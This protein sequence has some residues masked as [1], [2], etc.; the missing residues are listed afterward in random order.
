MI[1][2]TVK[3]LAELRGC[4]VRTIQKQIENGKWKHEVTVNEKDVKK[5]L[6]PLTEL[7]EE[8]QVKYYTQTNNKTD[9]L[10]RR[11]AD[12]I[13]DTVSSNLYI[14]EK[15]VDNKVKKGFEEY[16]ALERERI[17]MWRDIVNE[18]QAFRNN[19]CN[20]GQADKDFVYCKRVE[21]MQKGIELKISKDILYKKHKF[22]KN[23]D[24]DGLLENRGK[25]KRENTVLTEQMKTV[26][27]YYYFN[28]NKMQLSKCVGHV[29]EWYDMHYPDEVDSIP[30]Y[31]T[32]NRYAK[33][34][35]KAVVRYLREGEKVAFDSATPYIMR[36]Y[37]EIEANDVWVADCHTIDVT[38]QDEDGKKH[39]LYIVAFLDA[40][41]GVLAGWFVTDRIC[42]DST[43][44][45]LRNA[46]ERFGIPKVVYFDNGREFLTY[47]L[48]GKGHRGKK[49]N[50][51]ETPPT[52]IQRLGIEMTNAI[53]RN[54]KAKPIE[55]TFYTFK[56][57]VSKLFDTYTGGHVLER[58]EDYNKRVK[59]GD[60][61]FDKDL[62]EYINL[63]VDGIYNVEPYGGCESQYKGMSRVD[64]WNKSIQKTI[65][66]TA[67]EQDLNLMLLRSSKYQKVKR[68]GVFI[69]IN[70]VKLNYCNDTTWT[71]LD[72][73]VYVRYNP[74]DPSSVRL[75]NKEDKYLD[76]V[77]LA[78]DLMVGYMDTAEE[79]AKG[80]EFSGNV[81]R[82]IKNMA[83]S[84]TANMD[85]SEKI[86]VID[87]AIRKAKRQIGDSKPIIP[88]TIQIVQANEEM[89]LPKAV[90]E[91][92]M[93]DLATMIENNTKRSRGVNID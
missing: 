7:S 11:E 78:N 34:I 4:T 40:K 59:N 50:I 49:N 93:I 30:S 75:Y 6:I 73:E 58:P 22:I 61:V 23:N 76:T 26:F 33:T 18:W 88:K 83:K 82:N 57:T 60:T 92:V 20:K 81:K 46:I 39:R 85:S 47:D 56:E 62:K 87:L 80:Q 64:V 32:F 89:E 70:G 53:V 67:T 21:F 71:M 17:N 55:R 12:E 41:S 27:S 35:P 36:M 54:A 48:A 31:N 1:Y 66:R 8:L 38:S 43:I 3:E 42:A 25:Y 9:A 91:T 84:L 14:E 28:Q 19:Y 63:I 37:D 90:G 86:D 51:V 2:L 65:Y 45:A 72:E 10:L 68:N 44:M 13:K 52:I 15:S 24:F 16:T 77:K 29:R 5:Y 79:I 74:N 69:T